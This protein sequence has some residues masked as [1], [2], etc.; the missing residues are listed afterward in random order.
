[1]KKLSKQLEIILADNI[2]QD[3]NEIIEKLG[4][5][6]KKYIVSIEY[7]SGWTSTDIRNTICDMIDGETYMFKQGG[8]NGK[9]NM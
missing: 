9:N 8:Q 4:K 6:I 3:D 1:M 5:E 7:D 2:G